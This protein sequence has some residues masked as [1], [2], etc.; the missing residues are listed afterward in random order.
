M[1][2]NEIRKGRKG[3]EE[4]GRMG[5][6]KGKREKEKDNM[7]VEVSFKSTFMTVIRDESE[8]DPEKTLQRQ[9]WKETSQ[10]RSCLDTVVG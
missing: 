8:Q 2:W 5:E 7:M 10:L 1:D 9:R 4:V 3:P 6:G